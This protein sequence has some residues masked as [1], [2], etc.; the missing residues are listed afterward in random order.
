MVNQNVVNG[1]WTEIKGELQKT[2]GKITGDE[3]DKA[4]G[5]LKSL[6]GVIRQKYGLAQEDVS[7]K[8][9]DIVAKFGHDENDKPVTDKINADPSDMTRQ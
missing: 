4:K 2:W 6:A 1:K 3:F 8:L 9:N 5:D 7:Q